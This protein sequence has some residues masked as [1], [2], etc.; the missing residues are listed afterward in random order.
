MK[1]IRIELTAEDHHALRV[2]AARADVTMRQFARA[3]LLRAIHGTDIAGPGQV[4]T[5]A[6][7]RDKSA[8]RAA[9]DIAED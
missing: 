5:R 8:G 1:A 3:A 6:G 2:A 9:H 7:Q 4:P